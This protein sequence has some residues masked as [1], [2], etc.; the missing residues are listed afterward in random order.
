MIQFISNRAQ[1]TEVTQKIQ[2]AQRFVWIGTADIKNLHVDFQGQVVPFLKVL[3]FLLSNKVEIRLLHAKE[4]GPRFQRTFDQYPRLWDLME[5]Q[6]CPRVH[7]KQIIVDGRW[8][9]V[10]SANLTG[11]GMGMRSVNSRN[12]ETGVWSSESKFVQETMDA[13]DAVWMG[14][15]C[16]KCKLRAQCPDPIR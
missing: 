9:Y 16:S 14:S 13:F 12:F 15:F 5:R 10:G 1:Y 7:F 8:A 3:D 6:L 4:P 2:S 11:A